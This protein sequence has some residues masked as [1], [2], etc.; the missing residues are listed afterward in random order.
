MKYNAAILKQFSVIYINKNRSIDLNISA[1]EVMFKK[2]FIIEDYLKIDENMLKDIDLIFFEV[3]ELW[4]D[5]I[6]LLD[7]IKHFDKKLPVVL[8]TPQIDKKVLDYSLEF[9][10]TNYLI[11]PVKVQELL[12]KS[13]YTIQ[14]YHRKLNMKN[15]IK[16]LSS[17]IEPL[18]SEVKKLRALCNYQEGK[19]D[20]YETIHEE[21]LNSIKVD[22]KGLIISLS[23]N[24]EKMLQSNILGLD[25][26]KIFQTPSKIQKAFLVALKDRK[27]V[28]EKDILL[29]FDNL[30]EKEIKIM[31]F[32]EKNSED[33]N[34]YFFYI[35]I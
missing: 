23:K 24:L 22:K 11:K 32:F 10:I 18:N 3:D 27:L 19:I 5:E 16:I 33:E 12:K 31:P 28:V 2:I 25:I 6:V 26:S 21:F 30:E 14:K 35:F 1:V 34:S 17:K 13:F 8:I 29:I 20:F 4:Q 9:N 7:R 15:S